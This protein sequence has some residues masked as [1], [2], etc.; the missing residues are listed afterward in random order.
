M[1]SYRIQRGKVPALL[2][3]DISGPH[4]RV[5]ESNCWT[6]A[7]TGQACGDTMSHLACSGLD[8]DIDKQRRVSSHDSPDDVVRTI[9]GALSSSAQPQALT[10][11]SDP[12]KPLKPLVAPE[13]NRLDVMLN[14]ADII[15]NAC[16]ADGTSDP[17]CIKCQVSIGLHGS[18]SRFITFRRHGARNAGRRSFYL[19]GSQD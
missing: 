9:V 14:P 12:S 7:W 13:M 11:H 19:T 18:L 17:L 2:H 3:L 16:V 5:S 8:R 15:T 1:G 10:Q 4:K 6:A